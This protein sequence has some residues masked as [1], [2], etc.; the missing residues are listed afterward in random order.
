MKYAEFGQGN[1]SDDDSLEAIENDEEGFGIPG[2]SAVGTIGFFITSDIGN[3]DGNSTELVGPK[4]VYQ[5]DVTG[6]PKVVDDEGLASVDP[7]SLSTII[8]GNKMSLEARIAYIMENGQPKCGT[9]GDYYLP[10]TL[11]D[12]KLAHCGTCKEDLDNIEGPSIKDLDQGKDIIKEDAKVG[13]VDEFI[14]LFQKSANDS[15]MYYRGY[16]DAEQGKQLDEDLALLSDDYFHG[17]EQRKFY[18]KTPQQS[19]GQNVF[20]IKPN[21]NS[22]PRGGEMKPEQADAGPLQLTDGSNRATA[23]KFASIYPIDVIA[24]FFEV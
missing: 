2:Q 19:S 12:V 15:E 17:Y 10:K 9:C 7:G 16:T 6:K 8:E 20:D 5:V 1:Y 24:K 14:N 3:E 18:N 11:K 21:S 22:I 13:S 4:I 23:S